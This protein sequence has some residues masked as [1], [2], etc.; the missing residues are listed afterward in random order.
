MVSLASN[1][2]LALGVC[3]T[4]QVVDLFAIRIQGLQKANVAEELP[5][6]SQVLEQAFLNGFCASSNR[7]LASISQ[8][9]IKRNEFLKIF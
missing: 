7:S 9:L 6:L 8:E 3:N 4:C 2:C 5:S 1:P